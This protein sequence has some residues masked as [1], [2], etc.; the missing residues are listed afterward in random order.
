VAVALASPDSASA[1]AGFDD[2]VVASLVVGLASTAK[3][4]RPSGWSVPGES[5]SLALKEL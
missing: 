3:A 2:A 5:R 4:W 1:A